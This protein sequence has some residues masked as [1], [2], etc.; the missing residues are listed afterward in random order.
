MDRIDPTADDSL[1]EMRA[2]LSSATAIAPTTKMIAMT[3]SNSPMVKPRV[4]RTFNTVSCPDLI[5]ASGG[6]LAAERRHSS[7][8]REGL[9]RRDASGV[10][11]DRAGLGRCERAVAGESHTDRSGRRVET[12]LR[13]RA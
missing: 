6:G 2:R 8:K 12:G 11:P 10:L 7:C 4:S 5:V 1:A 13:R 9:G 3:T